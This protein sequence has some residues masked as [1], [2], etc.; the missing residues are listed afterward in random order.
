MCAV[1]AE[2]KLQMYDF[3]SGSLLF[4]VN[5]PSAGAY[6]LKNGMGFKQA[7]Q[8]LFFLENDQVL[9]FQDGERRI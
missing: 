4:D 9:A 7:T 5:F 3:I 6:C 8:K 2:R 1:L